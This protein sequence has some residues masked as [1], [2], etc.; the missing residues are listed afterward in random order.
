[1][2]SCKPQD[3]INMMDVGK[4]LGC[5]GNIGYYRT[6]EKNFINNTKV[7]YLELRL[8]CPNLFE[9]F[10]SITLRKVA[11]Y[12]LYQK[13]NE[14]DRKD[15]KA[16]RVVIKNEK[17]SSNDT[18]N[19]LSMSY[20]KNIYNSELIVH[21]YLEALKNGKKEYLRKAFDSDVFGI[22]DKKVD[23]INN[24]FSEFTK[25]MLNES[26]LYNWAFVEDNHKKYRLLVFLTNAKG[27]FNKKFQFAL[28]DSLKA[29]KNI[30]SIKFQ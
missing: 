7:R 2:I 9:V 21:Q 22:S 16:I 25:G 20:L 1:M 23:S 26:K 28:H 8:D 29:E 19:L 24:S 4:E 30:V 14:K 3:Y 27:N 17:L 6:E 12:R 11:A 5:S 18:S 13:L 15:Y 10:D